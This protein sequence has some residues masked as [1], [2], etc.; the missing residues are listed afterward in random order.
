MNDRRL[1]IE[2][3]GRAFCVGATTVNLKD[4][5]RDKCCYYS[6]LSGG[7]ST[8]ANEIIKRMDHVCSSTGASILYQTEII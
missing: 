8:S 6:D 4:V 7:W 3:L 5:L 1:V 2:R